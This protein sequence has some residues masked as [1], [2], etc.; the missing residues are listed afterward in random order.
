MQPLA[1]HRERK[2]LPIPIQI[3]HSESCTEILFWNAQ[4]RDEEDVPVQNV[5]CEILSTRHFDKLK[6][7]R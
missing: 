6:Q 5:L 1:V 2:I 3:K 7:T 4:K